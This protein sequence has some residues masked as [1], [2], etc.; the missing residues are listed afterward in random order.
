MTR[1][2]RG[3]FVTPREGGRR[4][5]RLLPRPRRQDTLVDAMRFVHPAYDLDP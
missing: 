2:G 4:R 3:G 1:A 5:G